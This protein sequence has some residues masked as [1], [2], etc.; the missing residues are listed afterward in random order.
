MLILAL[1][2]CDARGS[3]AVLRDA[4]VLAVVRHDSTDNY[5][6]WLLPAVQRTLASGAVGLADV[7]LFAVAAGPG[8]F[9]ALRVG[10]TSV[11]AW[12]EVYR[13]PVV[14][15]SRLEAMAEQA[16]TSSSLIAAFVDAR[17]EQIFSGLYRRGSTGLVLQD[18]EAVISPQGFLKQVADRTDSTRVAW[19][20]LDPDKM[21]SLRGWAARAARGESIQVAEPVI[22]PLIGQI[23]VRRAREGKLADSLTLDANYI[24]RSD[25]EIF[26][27]GSAAHGK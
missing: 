24:R 16:P 19:I 23:A 26:W 20:S 7:E 21:T 4:S 3:I 15:V 13:R 22:A 9:T 1:D 17:R 12:S 6:S 14:P 11:K 27:K 25:A 8:S 18:E 2:A 10:L 5:S